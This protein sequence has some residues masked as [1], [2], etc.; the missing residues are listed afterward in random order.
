[1]QDTQQGQGYNSTM[2]SPNDIASH[3]ENF[4][5]SPLSPRNHA[6][7]YEAQV[8][9]PVS[10]VNPSVSNVA[11]IK[12][13]SDQISTSIA[14][15]GYS[16]PPIAKA[17]E[18][19]DVTSPAPPRRQSVA[20]ADVPFLYIHGHLWTWGQVYLANTSS[21]D[22]FINPI[23]SRRLSMVAIPKSTS[24]KSP[25]S[26]TVRALVSPMD[27]DRK[28]FL[29]R[30]HF[31]LEDLRATIP[32]P[33]KTQLTGI[34]PTRPRRSGRNRRASAQALPV[35]LSSKEKDGLKMTLP[36]LGKWSTPIRK[37]VPIRFHNLS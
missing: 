18:V 6:T 23:S 35:N 32:S 36:R 8:H 12:L 1:M 5:F 19:G 15:I 13:S 2:P 34:A 20:A 17:L 22:A 11:Q 4:R 28:P 37:F 9:S 14:D 33:K 3:L 27:K 16:V 24:P 26:T 7:A 10:D 31:D 25:T 29:L 30:R 21:A